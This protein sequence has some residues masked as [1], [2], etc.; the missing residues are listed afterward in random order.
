VNKFRVTLNILAVVFCILAVNSL[1]HAQTRTWVSGVG[2]DA[3]PC[4][5][6]A[7]CKTFA[8][9]I[10]K[11]SLNGEINCLDPGGFGTVTITKSITIDCHEVF[12]SVLNS[13]TNGINIPFDNFTAVGET[14]KTVRL[15]NLNFNGADTGLVGINITG[16]ACSNN[17]EVFVEDCLLDGNF[18]GT[19]RGI[20][21]QRTGSNTLLSINNTTVR[22]MNSTGISIVGSSTARVSISRSLVA[23]CAFGVAA[24]QG[25]ITIYD[26]VLVSNSTSGLDAESG[27]TMDVD[28]CV[29]AKNTTS[30]FQA[31]GAGSAIRV[32]NTTAVNNGTMATASAGGIVSSYGNNQTAGAA[33]PS[34][35]P[36]PL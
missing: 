20:F 25:R 36:P 8:G 35:N 32:S 33:F 10:S 16:A 11:T 15:R 31:N 30:G 9:A 6:T 2:N 28:H 22:D 27:A 24:A 3:N 29:V 12:A 14:R 21:D 1:A 26:T 17:S 5:R 18:S 23:N 19:A 34:P 7:P 4:S 13:G